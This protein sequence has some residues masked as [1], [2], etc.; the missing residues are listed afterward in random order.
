MLK[1]A[2]SEQAERDV[3]RLLAILGDHEERIYDMLSD[4]ELCDLQA[5]ELRWDRAPAP[6]TSK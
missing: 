6:T 5:I 2:T 4:D 1:T 3:R